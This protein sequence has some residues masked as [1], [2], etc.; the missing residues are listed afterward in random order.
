MH[1]M[2]TT[3]HPQ[4]KNRVCTGSWLSRPANDTAVGVDGA[5]SMAP[6]LVEVDRRLW[7]E[8]GTGLQSPGGHG[9]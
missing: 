6:D 2:G 1:L 4:L 3:V 7:A 8:E 5:A 9:R